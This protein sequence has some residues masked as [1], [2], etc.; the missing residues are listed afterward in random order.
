MVDKRISMRIFWVFFVSNC[1]L[2]QFKFNCIVTLL[3][4]HTVPAKIVTFIVSW[5]EIFFSCWY[6]S[7]PCVTCHLI[8][9]VTALRSSFK[10]AATNILLYLLER[11]KISAWYNQDLYRITV[12]KIIR[13]VNLFS[14]RLTWFCFLFNVTM[15][16]HLHG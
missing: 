5:K 10:F 14:T 13:F 2:E 6:Q 3:S 11:I 8:A 12:T 4:F 15:P 1:R 7:L 16:Y 9:A